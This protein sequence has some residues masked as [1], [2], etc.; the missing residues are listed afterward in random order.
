MAFPPPKPA[1][2][3]PVLP[4]KL[5]WW[6][7]LSGELVSLSWPYRGY[8]LRGL[9]YAV[10]MPTNQLITSRHARSPALQLQNGHA[11][12]DGKWPFQRSPMSGHAADVIDPKQGQAEQYRQDCQ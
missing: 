5:V 12:D 4:T 7:D 1:A 3:S 9:P 10:L 11:D 6:S 2:A 8:R